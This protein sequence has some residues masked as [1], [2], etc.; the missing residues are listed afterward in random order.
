[1]RISKDIA[2]LLVDI[3]PTYKRYQ[4]NDGSIIVKLTKALYGCIES[5]KLWYQCMST[6][7]KSIFGM[8]ANPYD[9][10]VFNLSRNNQQLTVAIYVDDL[11]FTRTSDLLIS[12]LMN[13]LRSEF[14]TITDQSGSQLSYLGMSLDFSQAGEVT[15]TMSGYVDEIISSM[16]VD[17][18]VTTPASM[19]FFEVKAV[20]EDNRLL[21]PPDKQRFHT[22]VAKLLYLSQRTRPDI[23]TAVVFL[24]SR[25]LSP[26]QDDGRKLLRVVKYLYHTRTFGITLQKT[27]DYPVANCDASYGVHGDFKSQSGLFITLGKGPIYAGLAKQKLVAKSSTEAELI[28]LSDA[29]SHIIW[30]KHFLSAQTGVSDH[31]A[32]IYDVYNC[33]F[34]T[35][36]NS[37][38]THQAYIYIYIYKVFLS[39]GSPREG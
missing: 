29:S 15:F 17:S 10:C 12:E 28:A 13:F 2:D 35:D 9:P 19:N 30:T 1:M 24:T 25:G 20:S 23:Q 16:D 37:I 39:Q 31:P 38:E 21:P 14:Q 11:L 18:G 27:L 34:E 6:A 32:L 26:T 7:L 5:A 4:H 22:V 3:A 8:T 36:G 33:P